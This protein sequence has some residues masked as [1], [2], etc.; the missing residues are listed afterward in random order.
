M[1]EARLVEILEGTCS[2]SS[3]KCNALMTDVEQDLEE[4]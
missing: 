4:W 1:N 3:Y 2:Q